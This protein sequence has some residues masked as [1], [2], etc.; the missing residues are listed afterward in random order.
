VLGLEDVRVSQ[1][2]RSASDTACARERDD[3]RHDEKNE[4]LKPLHGNLLKNGASGLSFTIIANNKLFV[5]RFS[6]L[7]ITTF[8]V[9]IPN[10]ARS[11]SMSLI[12][13]WLKFP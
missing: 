9:S 3:E 6:G 12:K 4:E 8:I 1:G 11:R 2:A 7:K 5:N 13:I 10:S